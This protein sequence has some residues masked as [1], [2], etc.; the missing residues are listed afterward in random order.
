MIKFIYL[1]KK[2]Y[3]HHRPAAKVGRATAFTTGR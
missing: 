3:E 1:I 2:G